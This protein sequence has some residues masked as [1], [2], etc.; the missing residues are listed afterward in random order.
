M[1]LIVSELPKIKNLRTLIGKRVIDESLVPIGDQDMIN[2]T[3]KAQ[4][5]SNVVLIKADI[6]RTA[7]T[8]AVKSG[9][10]PIIVND[11]DIVLHVY[12]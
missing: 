11:D 6:E 2:V 3:Y 9:L 1:P 5:P 7:V 8:G 10:V 12:G 4:L